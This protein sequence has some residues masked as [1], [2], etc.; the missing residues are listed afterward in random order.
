MYII[1]HVHVHVRY[2]RSCEAHWPQTSWLLT[3]A[4]SCRESQDCYE[5]SWCTCVHV[6]FYT[7]S[8]CW[9]SQRTYMHVRKGRSG[10]VGMYTNKKLVARQWLTS[11]I[12]V[13]QVLIFRSG[14]GILTSLRKSEETQIHVR[15]CKNALLWKLHTLHR[16]SALMIMG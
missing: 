10:G 14:K 15:V 7:D 6:A 1:I 16:I 12:K 3:A 11:W 13:Q 4:E 8:L 5:V 2:S 9:S